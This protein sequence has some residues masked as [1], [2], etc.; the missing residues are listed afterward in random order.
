LPRPQGPKQSPGA[1]SGLG[2]APRTRPGDPTSDSRSGDRP[3]LARMFRSGRSGASKRWVGSESS[4][5]RHRGGQLP[6]RSSGGCPAPAFDAALGSGPS[7]S[8]ADL[9]RRRKN[10][11]RGSSSGS[12]RCSH[13]RPSR[14]FVPDRPS[15]T[16]N[17]CT[18]HTAD[19]WI[20]NARK[21]AANKRI[22]G[23]SRRGKFQ[24]N[25]TTRP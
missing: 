23:K 7:P 18:R 1:G 15:P 4:G 6:L 17:Q 11:L 16:G 8:L 5:L 19:V 13:I 3:E 20:F 14:R 25:V 24:G 21:S 10:S 22:S 9:T 2:L 12:V